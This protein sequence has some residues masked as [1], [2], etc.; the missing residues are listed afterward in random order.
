MTTNSLGFIGLGVMGEPMCR[1]LARKSGS[2]VHAHDLDSAALQ[3]LAADGVQSAG[4]I[5]AVMKHA[6]IVLLSLPSGEVVQ[7]LAQQPDGLLAN[8]RA[9]QI[10]I[11][12]STSPV[13]T[14][15]ALAKAFADKG[16][17]FIDAPVART[18]AAAEAGTL[19]VMVGADAATFERVKPLIATFATDIALCGPV[20]CGQ[21]VKI[22]NNMVLFETVVALSEAKAIGERA[23]VDPTLLFETLSKGSADS[24]ALRSHGMKAMLPGA[25]PERAFS[26][27]YA[28]KDL[29]YALKLAQE[30][31]VDAKSARIVDEWYQ[32][33]ID[34][35]LG[36]QYHPVVSR[37]LGGK[38]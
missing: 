16:V 21:V 7:Q 28:R 29:A 30:T 32:A 6:D 13:D 11:D 37:L 18:R 26:V 36:D 35:G 33:A 17:T 22:L 25:F 12:L 38:T 19:S 15:R 8:T 27:R 20:G 10:V 31:G 3:R 2:A 5:A 4:S 9:G 24:F 1:N 34:A 14:T 23:G